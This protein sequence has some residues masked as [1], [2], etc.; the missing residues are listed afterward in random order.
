MHSSHN[1]A[2]NGPL[3]TNTTM[4]FC[5]VVMARQVRP[6]GISAAGLWRFPQIKRQHHVVGPGLERI[7]SAVVDVGDVGEGESDVVD[8]NRRDY[9]MTT[10][11]SISSDFQGM[12]CYVYRSG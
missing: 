9:P 7:Y 12:G 6:N 3:V 4:R 10:S 5:V 2:R 8:T 11:A 1:P